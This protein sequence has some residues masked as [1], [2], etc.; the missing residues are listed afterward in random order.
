[1][2]AGKERGRGCQGSA[3]N[4]LDQLLDNPKL[5]ERDVDVQR[6]TRDA[7]RFLPR[8]PS[9]PIAAPPIGA[10]SRTVNAVVVT[11]FPSSDG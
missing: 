7:V 10:L 8:F 9:Q 6:D 2:H 11:R 4:R 3:R 1:M 5:L